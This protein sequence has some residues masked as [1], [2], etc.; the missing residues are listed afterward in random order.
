[1]TNK[2]QSEILITCLNDLHNSLNSKLREVKEEK[3]TMNELIELRRYYAKQDKKLRECYRNLKNA[4]A[5]V[6]EL[7]EVVAVVKK[8]DELHSIVDSIIKENLENSYKKKHIIK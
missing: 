2:N 6:Q 3:I 7:N 1:M 4:R 8:I 5:S